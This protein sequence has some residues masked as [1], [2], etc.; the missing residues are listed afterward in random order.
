MCGGTEPRE[1]PSPA[2]KKP[3]CLTYEPFSQIGRVLWDLCVVC[4]R[5]LRG[6]HRGGE[7]V[8]DCHAEG[9]GRPC[10]IALR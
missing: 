5:V 10:S 2:L 9:L 7:M 8:S 4:W 6:K 1:N 3:C